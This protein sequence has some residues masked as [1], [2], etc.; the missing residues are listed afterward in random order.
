MEQRN[1]REARRELET[2]GLTILRGVLPPPLLS[3]LRAAHDRVYEAEATTGGLRPE[4]SLHLL[5]F[6]DRDP[7]FLELLDVPPVLEL[8]GTV[9][10]PNVYAYHTH[11]DAHPPVRHA[12]PAWRWHQDGGRQNL[13]LESLPV[14]PRLS[15][16]VAF[17]LT[18][19]TRADQGAMLV[20]RRSH[21]VD[22]LER[23]ART[24]LP[25]V[26][27]RGAEP[28]LVR[29]GDAVVF[30][31]RLWHARGENRSG[32]TRKALFVG[33]TYRWI[34]P[35]ERPRLDR[36]ELNRLAPLRRQLLGAATTP[37]GHWLPANADLPLRA[38]LSERGLLDATRPA[39]R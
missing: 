39:H 22:H 16:K 9:L 3:R 5:G 36:D 25:F 28:A 32:P 35:R 17:F 1:G 23:P 26:E 31:R 21:R 30:D 13:E 10:G 18:D 38:W 2:D 15:L 14:R 29:A 4:G 24:N 37:T 7:A 19:V 6:L 27:P 11:L 12:A 33:F 34:R 8:V 20:I